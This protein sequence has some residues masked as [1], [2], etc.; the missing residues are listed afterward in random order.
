M[1]LYQIYLFKK[2][3]SFSYKFDKRIENEN[4]KIKFNEEWK[5][6]KSMLD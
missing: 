4:D 3:K 2:I 1:V 6:R 5:K